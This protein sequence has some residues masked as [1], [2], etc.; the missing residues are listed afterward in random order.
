MDWEKIN[1][2]FPEGFA[3]TTNGP[4]PIEEILTENYKD[5]N[6]ILSH[7]S[8]NIVK[9]IENITWYSDGNM[10]RN[11]IYHIYPKELIDGVPLF[12]HL[13]QVT[14]NNYIKNKKTTF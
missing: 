5:L 7:P 6:L 4:I 10:T 3:Y 2:M 8:H 12:N 9:E 1:K 13:G 14:F 11:I